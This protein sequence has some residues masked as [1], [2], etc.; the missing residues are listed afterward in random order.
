MQMADAPG[1]LLLKRFYTTFDKLQ[2]R[3]GGGRDIELADR[4]FLK[5][6]I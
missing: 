3:F 2:Y 5:H 4:C 1:L 6:R